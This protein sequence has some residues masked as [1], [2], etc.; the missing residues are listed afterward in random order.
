[1]SSQITS[2]VVVTFNAVH[3]TDLLMHGHNFKVEIE[4]RN[5]HPS[6]LNTKYVVADSFGLESRIIKWI[7]T[8][9]QYQNI[10]GQDYNGNSPTYRLPYPTASAEC[11]TLHLLNVINNE[12]YANDPVE[13]I[14]IKLWE[15][16]NSYVTV[17][18]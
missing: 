8:H 10:A 4:M 11:M 18:T 14:R 15:T 7:G 5:N 9:W 16:G 6:G 17:T 2:T 12:L 13:C 3:C 1:M